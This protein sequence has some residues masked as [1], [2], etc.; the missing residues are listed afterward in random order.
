MWNKVSKIVAYNNGNVRVQ[1]FDDGTVIRYSN[2]DEFDFA[3]PENIDLKISNKCTGTECP[4][5]HEGSGPEGKHGDILNAPWVDTLFKYQEVAIG[6][7]NPLEHPNLI[8]F[9]EILKEKQVFA[10]ITVNQIHFMQCIEVLKWLNKNQLIRGIGISFHHYDEDFIKVVEEFPNAVLHVI[11][12]VLTEEELHKLMVHHNL[13]ILILGYKRIRRGEMYYQQDWEFNNLIKSGIVENIKM[14]ESMMSAMFETFKVVSFDC[15]AI[16][17][18]HV[19]DHLPKQDWERF[20]QGE[21]GTMTFYI[22]AVNN[23]FAESSTASMNER[24]D[25]G[26]LSISEMFQIIKEKHK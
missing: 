1:R 7:G 10:N 24:Y 23:Q 12:G 19:K 13:K 4:W 14:I 2:D 8:S 25:I 9:L 20:Y 26:D 17:Q 18:L 5:C 6:G 11:A 15:L 16:E 3:F 22:D 21:D